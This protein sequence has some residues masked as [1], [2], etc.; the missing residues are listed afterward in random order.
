VTLTPLREYGVTVVGALPG[1]LPELKLPSLRLRDVD[2]V[3]P[4]A[5]A[6]FLL[7]Y[8]EGVSA[9]RTLA[10]RHGDEIDPRR[11]LLGLG[12]ANLAVAF[13]QGFPVAG[14]LSQSAVND[15]AGARSRLALVIASSV[16]AICLLFLTGLLRNL[17]N[18]VLAVVVLNAVRGL[19]DVTAVQRLR[20]ISR[21]EFAVA[22]VAFTGVLLLGILKGVVLAAVASLL[23]V[24]AAAARPGIAFLGR[25][26]GTR[27]YSDL[28]RHPDN[29]SIPGVLVFR[30]E[31]SIL[32]FNADYV[33]K[34][35]SEKVRSTAGLR[36]VISDMS[37]SPQVDIAG[38]KM[39]LDLQRELAESHIQ[40][41]ISEPHAG[42]RDLLRAAGLEEKIGYFGRRLSLDQ[43]IS[44]YERS[45][46]MPEQIAMLPKELPR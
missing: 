12:A 32:Y 9:A 6:C 46:S 24:V 23:M 36:V 26:P 8:I 15:Q 16:L 3:I 18:V 41:R 7:A 5:S 30:V 35:V 19:I 27:R 44:D 17:P 38:A 37:N 11:E 40:F 1:G 43:V 25:I 20:R 28:T 4:L 2:G 45:A 22:V 29:E 14:G 21:I 13:G 39:L 33:R 10:A 42:V 31:A 34:A